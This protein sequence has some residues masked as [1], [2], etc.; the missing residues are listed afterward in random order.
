MNLSSIELYSNITTMI[1]YLHESKQYWVILK[2][3]YN[4]CLFAWILAVLSYTQIL[5][6]WLPICI[7]IIKHYHYLGL[8][9]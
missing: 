7:I 9:Q 8:N 1:A 3:Y 4:D 5:L 6:Q 2:Y